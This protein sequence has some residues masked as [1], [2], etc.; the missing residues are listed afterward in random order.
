MHLYVCLLQGQCREI[1]TKCKTNVLS[2][3]WCLS[4][5]TS[6]EIFDGCLGTFPNYHLAKPPRISRQALFASLK[7]VMSFKSL[8]YTHE[9]DASVT[10][11]AT[12]VPV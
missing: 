11:N 7:E 12:T 1:E 2:L 9:G 6:V 4:V 10:A 5:D 3:N 8:A